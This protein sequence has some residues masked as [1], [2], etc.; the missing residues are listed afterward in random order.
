MQIKKLF[1]IEV[2]SLVKG[3][4]VVLSQICVVILR[5]YTAITYILYSSVLNNTLQKQ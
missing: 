2:H 3:I 1:Q 4:T 5:W